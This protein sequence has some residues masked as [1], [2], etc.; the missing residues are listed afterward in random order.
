MSVTVSQAMPVAVAVPV[1]R[2][3]HG[4]SGVGPRRVGIGDSGTDAE[5]GRADDAGN[6]DT[7][8]QSS[9]IHRVT[10]SK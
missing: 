6:R 10:P 9:E 1:D 5:C 3:N 8:N 2:L 7:A 4:S